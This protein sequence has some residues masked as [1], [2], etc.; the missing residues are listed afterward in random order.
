MPKIEEVE[1]NTASALGLLEMKN[2][3][4]GLMEGDKVLMGQPTTV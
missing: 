4:R 1:D 2:Q 3:R